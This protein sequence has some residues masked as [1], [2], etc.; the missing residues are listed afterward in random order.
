LHRF[1]YHTDRIYSMVYVQSSD[2]IWTG[3]SD[4]M[5]Q[6]W[7]AKVR[8]GHSLTLAYVLS[9]S[10]SYTHHTTVCRRSRCVK[11]GLHMMHS[12]VW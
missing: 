9:L 12:R 7:D 1:K 2:S 3:S 11:N 10:L 5:I 8:L 4:G 6:V